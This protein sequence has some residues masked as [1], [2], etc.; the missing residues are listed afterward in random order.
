MHQFTCSAHNCLSGQKRQLKFWG[1]I[2]C[3]SLNVSSQVTDSI[4]QMTCDQIRLFILQK[5]RLIQSYLRPANLNLQQKN[6]VCGRNCERCFFLVQLQK[7]V[8]TGHERLFPSPRLGMEMM[9]GPRRFSTLAATSIWP[10]FNIRQ[11]RGIG[12]KSQSPFCYPFQNQWAVRRSAG[13]VQ[14]YAF[15]PCLQTTSLPWPLGAASDGPLRPSWPHPPA[16]RP[17]PMASPRSLP[18]HTTQWTTSAASEAREFSPTRAQINGLW[19]DAQA[20]FGANA[21]HRKLGGW[22]TW[23]REAAHVIAIWGKE[24]PN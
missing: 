10:L 3:F 9:R 13:E 11:P 4:P 23:G 16:S 17:P 1:A 7:S 19:Q 5:T 20:S 22:G 12:E 8:R 6:K 14:S 24:N 15:L 21:C 2:V 18:L